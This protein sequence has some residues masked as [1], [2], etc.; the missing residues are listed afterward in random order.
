MV[1]FFYKEPSLYA[2]HAMTKGFIIT[3]EKEILYLTLYGILIQVASIHRRCDSSVFLRL[4]WAFNSGLIEPLKE[5]DG[6]AANV[7]TKHRS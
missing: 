5:L 6:P 4:L 3:E 1:Y 2:I 7:E